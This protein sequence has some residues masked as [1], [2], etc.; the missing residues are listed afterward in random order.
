M[1]CNAIWINSNEKSRNCNSYK[2]WKNC[3]QFENVIMRWKHFQ[4][5]VKMFKV[6]KIFYLHFKIIIFNISNQI[7]FIRVKMNIW[8]IKISIRFFRNHFNEIIKITIQII[9]VT[10]NEIVK[11]AIIK[12]FILFIHNRTINNDWSKHFH[13]RNKFHE[14][15]L[16]SIR[17]RFR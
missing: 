7:S 14:R 5:N 16:H 10:I 9:R 8:T 2:N 12:T 13:N 3:K 4:K 15:N 11:I 17:R 1:I 6:N